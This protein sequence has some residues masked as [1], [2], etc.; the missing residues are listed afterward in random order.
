MPKKK[1]TQKSKNITYTQ[2]SPSKIQGE[3]KRTAEEYQNVKKNVFKKIQNVDDLLRPHFNS[4]K[5]RIIEMALENIRKAIKYYFN[6]KTLRTSRREA[7]IFLESSKELISI[8]RFL[9]SS[10]E[11]TK[12]YDQ[13]CAE[14]NE[15]RSHFLNQYQYLQNLEKEIQNTKKADMEPQNIW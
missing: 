7:E 13:V 9:P 2:N 15:I 10:K 4:V 12:T 14:L 8:A 3:N 5:Q 6:E 1:T 11:Q